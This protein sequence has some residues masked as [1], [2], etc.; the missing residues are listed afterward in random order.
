MDR[1]DFIDRTEVSGFFRD[2]DAHLRAGFRQRAGR[3][4]RARHGPK[5]RGHRNVDLER[6][7]RRASVVVERR[8][9]LL[10]ARREGREGLRDVIGRARREFHGLDT[11]QPPERV[12]DLRQPRERIL[13]HPRTA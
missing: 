12:V 8:E 4:D 9:A 3:S 6:R 1:F 2:R 11:E 7:A 5:L 10:D 13:H